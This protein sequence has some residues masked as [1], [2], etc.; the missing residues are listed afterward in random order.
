MSLLNGAPCGEGGQAHKPTSAAARQGARGG[1]RKAAP[2]TVRDVS[3]KNPPMGIG[4]LPWSSSLLNML[5]SVDH[6]AGSSM[7][8]DNESMLSSLNLS[9]FGAKAEILQPNKNILAKI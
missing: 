2:N 8:A 9:E 6:I 3:A 7:G 5:G 1:G 4:N